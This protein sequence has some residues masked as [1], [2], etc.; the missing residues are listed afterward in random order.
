MYDN[1]PLL[2]CKLG[3]LGSLFCCLSVHV[4]V[5]ISRLHLCLSASKG[6][7]CFS[8]NPCIFSGLGENLIN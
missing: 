7:T 2:T 1:S 6:D 4:S 3:A 8:E 5:S